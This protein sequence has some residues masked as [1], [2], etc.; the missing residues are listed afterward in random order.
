MLLKR[1]HIVGLYGVNRFKPSEYLFC[2]EP[3]PEL[4]FLRLESGRLA[5][6]I[7]FCL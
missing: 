5:L 7:S 3:S 6:V 1:V 4:G 2:R